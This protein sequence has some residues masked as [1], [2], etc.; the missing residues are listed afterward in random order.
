M[1]SKSP[2]S[3]TGSNCLAKN[4]PSSAPT[5]KAPIEPTLPNTAFLIFGTV[6]SMGAFRVGDVAKYRFLDIFLQ[7]ADELMSNSQIEFVFAGFGKNDGDRISGNVL[8][9]VYV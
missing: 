3:K 7:L 9:L 8:K 1:L 4:S 2:A 6:G 5:R